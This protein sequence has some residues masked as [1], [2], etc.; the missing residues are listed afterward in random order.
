MANTSAYK[1][2]ESWL[3][4][5]YLAQKYPGC[6]ITHGPLKLKWG[7][8]FEYDA[9]VYKSGT[10]LAAYCLSCSEYETVGGKGGAGKL[11]KIKSDI[12]MMVGTDC[13]NLILA[14]SGKTMY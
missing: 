1:K 4:K 5:A 13:P 6:H 9:L 3:R 2:I 8:K 14:F 11:Q 10:L 7:G 12:L